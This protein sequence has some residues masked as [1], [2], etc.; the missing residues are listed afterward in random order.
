MTTTTST[1]LLIKCFYK[2]YNTLGYG[3][4]EKVYERALVIELQKHGMNCTTQVPISVFYG[5]ELV[6]EYYADVLVNDEIILELKTALTIAPEHEAQLINYLKATEIEVG[7]LFNFGKKP[8][9]C[10]KVFS[11]PHRSA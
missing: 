11:N 2:V 9:F 5:N 1:D 4:L 6:G 7:Y 8:E 3:F 10:R